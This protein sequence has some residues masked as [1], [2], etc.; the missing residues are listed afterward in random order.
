MKMTKVIMAAAL[1]CVAI[2]LTSCGIKDDDEFKL[3]TGSNK[4]Y[5]IDA[6][7]DTDNVIRGYD[8]TT[9]KHIGATVVISINNE[10][11]KSGV[12]GFIFNLEKDKIVKDTKDFNII[13]FRTTDKNGN[14]QYYVSKYENIADIQAEN[15]GAKT[16]AN[17]ANGEAYEKELKGFSSTVKGKVVDGETKIVVY[18]KPIQKDGTYQQ[19]LYLLEYDSEAAF[20]NDGIPTLDSSAKPVLT[21][22]TGVTAKATDTKC[23]EAPQKECAVYANIYPTAENKASTY[24]GTTGS[25]KMKGTWEYKGTYHEGEIELD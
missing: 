22:D 25:G 16:T 19:E 14:M 21:L 5:E 10:N 20:D 23:A 13:G 6:T 8:T 18:L 9:F 4:K 2:G 1:A 11:V 7:N 3:I 12:M 24:T 15:F 17:S